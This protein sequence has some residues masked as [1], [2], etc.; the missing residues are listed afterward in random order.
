M[1][2]RIVRVRLVVWS[3]DFL[4]KWESEKPGSEDTGDGAWSRTLRLHILETKPPE[5]YGV[6]TIILPPHGSWPLVLIFVL[7]S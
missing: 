1:H 2:S 7:A 5:C 3:H 6:T 4:P